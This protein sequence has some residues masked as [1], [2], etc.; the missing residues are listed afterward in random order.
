METIEKLVLKGGEFLIKET[1]PQDIFIPE[2]WDEE[3]Q[4]IAQT[5]HDFLDQEVF[6]KLDEIDEMQEGLM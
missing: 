2:E 6:T 3:Q 5:C 4:M 1:Y